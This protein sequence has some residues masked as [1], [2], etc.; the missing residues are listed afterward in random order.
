[1]MVLSSPF[2][3][4]EYTDDFEAYNT[5]VT[6]GG[7]GNWVMEDGDMNIITSF[8]D[9]RVTG[10]SSQFS[11]ARYNG[12]FADNQYS[13]IICDSVNGTAPRYGPVVRCATG[14]ATYYIFEGDADDCRFARFNADTPTELVTGGDPFADGDKIELRVI[15]Y[16][17]QFYRNDALDTSMSG[18]GKFTDTD[19]DKIA[20][21]MAGI[22]IFGGDDNEKMAMDDWEG[23]SL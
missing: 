9:K 15:G 11:A 16:E 21:G 17:F 18:D 10:G 1:M 6:I 4:P 23:G 22:G 19:G 13:I 5:G 20:S 2:S 14:A 8:G 7:Q 12:T 3:Y